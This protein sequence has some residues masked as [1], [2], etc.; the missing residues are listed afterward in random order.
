MV[1]EIKEE[2]IPNEDILFYRIPKS[3]F[4]P[5]FDFDDIP[6]VAFTPQ[7]NYLSTNWIKYCSSP[8]DCLAIKTPKFPNGKTSNSHGIGHFIAGEV[9]E[10]KFLDVKLEVKHVVPSAHLSH[11]GI[12][13]IPPSK[14]KAPFVEMRF[15]LKRI[16]KTW[17]IKPLDE[18]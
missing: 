2:E 13:N 10:L 15:K 9:R 14:P 8:E 12:F 6:P 7:G 18:I 16:F 5:S 3:I 11:A 17:D 4:N 1:D